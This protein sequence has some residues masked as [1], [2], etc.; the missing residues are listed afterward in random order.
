MTAPIVG[1]I[2]Q[3]LDEEL[4]LPPYG[5]KHLFLTFTEAV[6][7][8]KALY[9]SYMEKCEEGLE[10]PFEIYKPTKKDVDI[11]GGAL[12]FRSRDIHIWIDCIHR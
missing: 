9:E 11:A 7:H 12:L 4:I 8:A 2:I 5:A 3:T 10:G 6:E 1:Y